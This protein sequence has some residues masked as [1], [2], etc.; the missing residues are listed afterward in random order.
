Q[1]ADLH[2][3]QAEGDFVRLVLTDGILLVGQTLAYFE[4]LLAD[5]GVL[6][7]HRSYLLRLDALTKLEGNRAHTPRGIV[8]VGRTYR[9]GLLQRL[10]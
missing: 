7:V 9:E 3:C 10:G 1:L 6:R 8:P 4:N 5:Y 2:Y